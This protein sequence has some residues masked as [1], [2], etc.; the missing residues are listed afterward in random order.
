MLLIP[1]ATSFY[2]FTTNYF[3][4][5]VIELIT[6]FRTGSEGSLSNGGEIPGRCVLYKK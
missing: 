2:R 1:L 5:A 4:L 3:V 6:I